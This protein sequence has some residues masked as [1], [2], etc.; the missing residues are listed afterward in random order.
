MIEKFTIPTNNNYSKYYTTKGQTFDFDTSK[1]RFNSKLSI[2]CTENDFEEKVI[3]PSLYQNY[4]QLRHYQ[5]LADRMN[6][7]LN[8]AN[9]IS[10]VPTITYSKSKKYISKI[11]IRATNPLVSSKKEDDGNKDFFGKYKEDVLNE[12]IGS[13]WFEFDV[14]SSVPRVQYLLTNGIWLSN[15]TDI[16]E[17]IYNEMESMVRKSDSKYYTTKGQTFAFSDKP[18][19]Q[20]PIITSQSVKSDPNELSPEFARM[21]ELS[22]KPKRQ[23]S[24]R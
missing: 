3:Y 21:C 18:K 16:Y 4:P 15:D 23:I 13:K 8:Q 5:E 14:K 7:G 10:F 6:Q 22:E 24:K 12:Q 2:P 17:L 9:Q 1:I 20:K 19:R 11:G